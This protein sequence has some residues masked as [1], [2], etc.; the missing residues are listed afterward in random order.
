MLAALALLLPGL[1][2]PAGADPGNDSRA[3]DLGECSQLQVDAG[4][5]VSSYL[6]GQGVQIYRWDG[7]SWRFVS[8]EAVLFADAGHHGA[9]C[10]HF[11]GPTWQSLSGSKVV[12]TVIDKCTPDPDSIPWLKLGA[13]SSEGPGIFEGVTFIQRLN[14]VGGNAPS[15]PG[16]FTGE[17][18]KVPYTADYVFYK[19]QD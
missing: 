1:A 12:G 5:R 14:T 18:A 19:Q 8:P 7:A 10:L 2:A 9:V 11:G 4:N 16:S 13:A 17:V 15:A 3:P 6:F